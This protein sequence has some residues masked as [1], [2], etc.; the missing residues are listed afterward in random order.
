M[1]ILLLGSGG[2]EHALAWKISQSPL[3]T[4]LFI[5]PGNAGTLALG[6]NCAIAVT[7]FATIAALCIA[8]HIEMVVVGPEEP[9]VKGI[10]EFLTSHKGLESIKIIGPGKEGAQ[11]EGSKAF[12]KS[13]MERHDIPT[14]RYKEFSAGNYEEGVAYLK[15]HPL[16]I[17]LKADGL[18]A[19]KGVLICET[20]Q[21]A[22]EGFE[23]MIQ[24]AR[25]GEAGK[26]VVVEQFLN[27]IEISVFV[28]TD[29]VNY[30]LLPEAKDYKRIGEG[31]K[32]PNTGGM[33]AVS[34]VPFVDTVLWDKIEQRV[35]VPTINGLRKDGIPYCGF[36]FVGF[37]IVAGDPYVIE[38]NCRMGDPETEVVIPRLATDL[39]A[40]LDA[41][42]T[43]RL[44]NRSV[45]VDPRTACTVV[46]VSG[47]YPDGYAKG[48][49]ISGLDQPHESLVF[50]MGTAVQ[51]GK[52]VTS[53]GRV[54]A[55]TSFANSVAE[56]AAQSQQVQQ[57]ILYKDKY[58]RTD[59]GYEFC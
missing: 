26:K 27:G 31:D 12:A 46:A 37:M 32:G 2:R 51:E 3:C 56:A 4:Q 8:E 19:G 11:L 58:C 14:A 38:Y 15:E 22:L 35:V 5:A 59:I 18:A 1:R 17:V 44:Q 57:R 20:T 53:G 30:T 6:T 33:G 54:L 39:V 9:L 47:G 40:L 36:I 28:L 43:G 21:E 23:A 13:F 16:P 52:V 49:P 55:V 45:P 7:D 48:Y 10:R 29:G 41:A 42:A 50:H 24:D 25:F 34:P